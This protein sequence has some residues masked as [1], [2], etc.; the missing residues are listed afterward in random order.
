[1]LAAGHAGLRAVFESLG[2][3]YYSAGHLSVDDAARS[4]GIDP[5]DV[6]GAITRASDA[7]RGPNW[8]DLPLFELIQ[9]LE[10]AHHQLLRSSLF[11][12]A[13]LLDDALARRHEVCVESLR[14]DFR[15]FSEV[16]LQHIELE[17]LSLF[18][19][20]VALEAAWSKGKR[21][22]ADRDRVKRAIRDLLL[23][24]RTIVRNLDAMVI[25]R[26][27]VRRLGDEE[28]REIGLNLVRIERHTHEYLNLESCALFPRLLALLSQGGE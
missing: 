23:E 9:H 22:R 2:L 25:D 6:R 19:V 16:L 12:T 14:H 13:V 24:H 15:A 21:L 3:D 10:T 8:L 7:D 18:P 27:T 1:M 28:C 5:A 4:A 11:K 20:A 26:D 17:E